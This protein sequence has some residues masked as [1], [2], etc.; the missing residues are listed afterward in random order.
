[1]AHISYFSS[2]I[3][4]EMQFYDH[5]WQHPNQQK[6]SILKLTTDQRD[7]INLSMQFNFISSCDKLLDYCCWVGW[8]SWVQISAWI[9]ETYLDYDR[10]QP[11]KYS[12]SNS[13]SPH[14]VAALNHLLW[15]SCYSTWKL[16]GAKSLHLTAKSDLI[17]IDIKLIPNAS[18]LP[19]NWLIL[20]AV[21][22]WHQP[23]GD[24]TLACAFNLWKRY[25]TSSNFHFERLS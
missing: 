2:V 19:S 13:T 11:S 18:R 16:H 5:H 6:P 20:S 17:E 1:M 8:R 22:I 21:L 4:W 24:N 10:W 3:E 12:K 23:S 25:R 7:D 14:F 9:S 15:R